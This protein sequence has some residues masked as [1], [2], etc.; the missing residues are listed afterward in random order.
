MPQLPNSLD[1]LH[2]PSAPAINPLMHRTNLPATRS[3]PTYVL[4]YIHAKDMVSVLAKHFKGAAE[5]QAVPES[6]VNVL[7]I[8]GSPAAAQR[9]S[10][11][12][13]PSWT[14]SRAKLLSMYGW[15]WWLPSRGA[16]KQKEGEGGFGRARFRRTESQ[17]HGRKLD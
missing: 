17:D 9:K 13:C 12:C 10:R 3:A 14:V 6:T 15:V 5:I 4:K 2:W 1:S 7:L 16:P 11:L 8:S